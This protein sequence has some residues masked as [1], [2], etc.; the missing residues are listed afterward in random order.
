MLPVAGLDGFSAR[1]GSDD[2]YA[3]GHGVQHLHFH[4]AAEGEGGDAQ[5]RE[6]IHVLEIGNETEQFHVGGA[7]D[8]SLQ[9]VVWILADNVEAKGRMLRLHLRPD[10]LEEPEQSKNVR[11]PAEEAD[12]DE[13]FFRRR[14]VHRIERELRAS[15]R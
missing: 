6:R 5:A 13:A 15:P 2:G 9:A 10:F 1:W 7:R 14:P 12:V 8:G 4:A 11:F 3:A